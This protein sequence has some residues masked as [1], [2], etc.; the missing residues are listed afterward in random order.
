MAMPKKIALVME[1]RDNVA[2]ALAEIAPDTEVVLTVAGA[3]ARIMVSERIPFAHKF[4][5]ADIPA[6]ALVVKYGQPIGAATADIAAGR[7]VHVHNLE[8]RRGR[9][10]R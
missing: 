10:D 3:P 8:S 4:A 5:L 9:G 6:G 1:A 2:T 7:H